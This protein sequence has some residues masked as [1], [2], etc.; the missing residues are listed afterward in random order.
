MT[1]EQLTRSAMKGHVFYCQMLD[2]GIFDI[3]LGGEILKPKKKKNKRFISMAKSQRFKEIQ[4]ESPFKPMSAFGWM[5]R[6]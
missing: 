2:T 1:K 6:K 5:P 4:K 3:S